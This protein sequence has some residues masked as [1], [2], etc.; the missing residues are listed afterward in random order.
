MRVLFDTNIILDLFLDR[1]PFAVVVKE[2]SDERKC[3][4][5]GKLRTGLSDSEE[6]IPS[7][8]FGKPFVKLRKFS[9]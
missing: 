2:V 3:H 5:F 7:R 6:S 1:H 8:S 4:S 9:G